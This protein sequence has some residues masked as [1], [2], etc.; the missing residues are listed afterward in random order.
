MSLS[1]HA[2]GGPGCARHPV[3]LRCSLPSASSPTARTGSRGSGRSCA[4]AEGVLAAVR[5]PRWGV[6]L[7]PVP[8]QVAGSHCRRRSAA[9]T[10]Q[11]RAPSS[12]KGDLLPSGD[13]T[14]QLSPCWF[15]VSRRWSL[16]SAFLTNTSRYLPKRVSARRATRQDGSRRP[17]CAS[18]S[19]PLPSAFITNRSI[20]RTAAPS[21]EGRAPLERG[22]ARRAIRGSLEVPPRYV[23]IRFPP[24]AFTTIER[25]TGLAFRCRRTGRPCRRSRLRHHGGG[26]GPQR[27]RAKRSPTG[28]RARKR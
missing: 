23:R 15:G 8:R 2:R 3:S 4:P 7:R 26:A 9:Q 21:R 27:R 28:Q 20:L 12:V 22:H 10:S 13:K 18:G 5:R 24:S 1:R 11:M 16:P 25:H 6:V 17:G 14:G 19:H